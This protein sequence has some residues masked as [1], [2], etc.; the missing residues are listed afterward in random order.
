[1]MGNHMFFDIILHPAFSVFI[2]ITFVAAVAVLVIARRQ[3]Q[4]SSGLK[5]ILAAV[6]ALCALYL[7]F[8]VSLVFLFN[9]AP[10][11]PPTPTVS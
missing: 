10:P 9:S 7:I 11:A 6:I 8:F 1:M 5:A 3:K 2:L 4:L